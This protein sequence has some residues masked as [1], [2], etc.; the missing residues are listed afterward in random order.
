[1]QNHSKKPPEVFLRYLPENEWSAWPDFL[2][3]KWS[4]MQSE[5]DEA[6]RNARY[7]NLILT[8]LNGTLLSVIYLGVSLALH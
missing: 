6:W 2:K 1:M 5:S 7:E 8:A 4:A 3:E